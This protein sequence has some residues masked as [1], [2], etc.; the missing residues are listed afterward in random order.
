ML[1]YRGV[2]YSCKPTYLTTHPTGDVGKYRGQ[3]VQF[4]AVDNPP[5]AYPFEAKLVYRGV[6]Y[7]VG[8]TAPADVPKAVVNTADVAPVEFPPINVWMRRLVMKHLGNIRRRE[9]SMLVR[10][11]KDVGLPTQEAVDYESHIQG[12]VP[13][14]FAGYDRSR[15]A[16]S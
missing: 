7:T 4:R 12:K 14:D 5:P 11:A 15:S 6:A 1:T 9:H 10:A 3:T 8:A 2:S 13:H 16:M